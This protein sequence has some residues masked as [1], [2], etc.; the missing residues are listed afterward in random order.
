MVLGLTRVHQRKKK[1][2]NILYSNL[3]EEDGSKSFAVKGK[4]EGMK[5]EKI[6]RDWGGGVTDLK[7]LLKS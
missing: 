2:E 5:R 6:H 7:D 4:K 3:K 1:A